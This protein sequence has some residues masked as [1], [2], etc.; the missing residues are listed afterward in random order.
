MRIIVFDIENVTFGIF[1][2]P[3]GTYASSRSKREN[4]FSEIIPQLLIN[5]KDSGCLGGD[6][7]F[8]IHKEDATKNPET[9]ISPSLKRLVQTFSW[10]DSF[11][12]L[13]PSS[14]SFSRY[15]NSDG[16]GDGA[17]RIDR[18][19]HFGNLT[20]TEAKYVGIAFSDHLALIITVK[21]SKIML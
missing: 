6:F 16:H 1:Y 12:S 10:Q 19:Y 8:I 11:R 7:N 15:Y 9:K 5:S 17:S 3:S 21:I 4:Y 14:R 13:F 18:N 20:V 2:L